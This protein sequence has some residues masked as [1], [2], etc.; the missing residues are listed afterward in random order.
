V[1]G[2]QTAGSM[3]T[4]SM[5]RIV[6]RGS[7]PGATLRSME[8][9][10]PGRSALVTGGGTGLGRAIAVAFS[11]RGASVLITG[12]REA[13]LRETAELL[14]E[15]GTEAIWMAGDVSIASHVESW[16]RTALERFGSLDFAC[17]NAA[18]E[19]AGGPIAG[20]AEE[21]FDRTVA[22]NLRGTWLCMKYEMRAMHQGGRGAIV[23]MSSLNADR[24]SAGYAAYCATKAAVESLTRTA[25]LEGAPHGIRVNA[26]RAGAFATDMLDRAH[27]PQEME[28][29]AS[30]IPLGRIGDPSEAAAFVT[31][32]CS[33][34]ASYVTGQS[35][36]IDGGLSAS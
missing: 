26:L 18:T 29:L 34:A 24:S 3:A 5:V 2:M 10:F 30:E 28:E 21:D 1:I 33:D 4:G 11:A 15:R 20:E 36:T 32:L 22:V 7:D 12:R 6:D 31:W 8:A 25:T 13:P 9:D 27:S 23:N 19:G 14:R 16:V 17:N 35:L